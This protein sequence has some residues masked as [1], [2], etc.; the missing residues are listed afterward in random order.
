VRYYIDVYPW[1]TPDNLVMQSARY[2]SYPPGYNGQRFFFDIDVPP[3][4]YLQ[5][6]EK[7]RLET[8][9]VPAP[10]TGPTG[11]KPGY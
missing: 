8:T 6:P 1:S 10:L 4:P 2:A 11:A 9:L 7:E 5:I 3:V